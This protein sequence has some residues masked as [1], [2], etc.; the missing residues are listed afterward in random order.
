MDE[1]N[2]NKSSKENYLQ[3]LLEPVGSLTHSCVLTI[4]GDTLEQLGITNH[5]VSGVQFKYDGQVFNRKTFTDDDMRFILAKIKTVLNAAIVNSDQRNAVQDLIQQIV[6]DSEGTSMRH[7][8]DCIN[9]VFTGKNQVAKN[10]GL[11]V[12]KKEY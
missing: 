5:L 6:W 10:S 11:V 7:I 3:L 8:N 9:R 2:Q 4:D 12:T 1:N